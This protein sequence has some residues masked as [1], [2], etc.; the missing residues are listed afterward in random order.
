MDLFMRYRSLAAAGEWNEAS[1]QNIYVPRFLEEMH[2][3]RAQEKLD[4]L[5]RLSEA[6]KNVALICFCAQ[7]NLCHRSVVAGLLQGRGVPV[8][9]ERGVS[10]AGYLDR[11]NAAMA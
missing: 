5:A 7:E 6:G 9:T 11:L 10:Y 3:P 1:F 2:D 8:R 4:E